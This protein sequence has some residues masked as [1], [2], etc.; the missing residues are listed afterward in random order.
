MRPSNK[1]DTYPSSAAVILVAGG[2]GERMGGNIPKQFQPLAGKPMLQ[3]TLESVHRWGK[4]SQIMVVTHAEWKQKTIEIAKETGINILWAEG[5]DTRQASVKA[6][7]EA[8]VPLNPTHVLVHDAARP[9]ASPALFDR[10]LGALGENLSVIPAIAVADSLKQGKGG[11]VTGAVAREGLYRAQ[12]PQGFAFSA[13]YDAHTRLAGQ[14]LSDDAALMEKI[15][16]D[17]ALVEGDA[18]NIKIT[19][20]EDRMQAEQW[21]SPQWEYR[22]LEYRTGHGVDVHPLV[23][24]A[25]RPLMLGGAEIPSPLALAGH[26]DADVL[27]HALTDALLGALG[28]GDIGMHFPPS[29]AKWKNAAS[30]QF[31]EHAL[32]L[33]KARG[34]KLTHID[35]T[36][37]GEAPRLSPHRQPIL[38]SLSRIT[39]LPQTR[40]GLK[41]TTTEKLGFL[42]RGEGAMAMATVTIALPAQV[43]A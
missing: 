39:G 19:V 35:I 8:L 42:G 17:T 7:L 25:T 5:G 2:S 37:M 30:A 36:L 4:A 32:H 34:G 41:A 24:D 12:T 27:L 10:V 21:L 16:V 26:S 28:E 33:L 31:V 6:G 22:P 9:L 15:G 29:D 38:E 18:R 43:D 23:E 1:H 40:I 11:L 13:I 3:Q 14:N 20:P